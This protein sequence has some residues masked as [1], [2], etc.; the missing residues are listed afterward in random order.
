MHSLRGVCL[1]GGDYLPG[2]LYG[3]GAIFLG[4]NCP[5]SNCP[6]GNHPG[7]NYP[8]GTYPGSNFP[9]GSCPKTLNIC[10]DFLVM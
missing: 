5:G 10:P 3:E 4:G 1:S 6:E 7:G 8:G 2:K 9:R